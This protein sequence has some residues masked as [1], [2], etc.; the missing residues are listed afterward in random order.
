MNRLSGTL[1]AALLAAGLAVLT[2]ADAPQ[3]TAPAVSGG[4]YPQM[5][6]PQ[7][8]KVPARF[9]SYHDYTEATQLLQ[10]LA[11]AYPQYAHLQSLGKSYGGREMWV[12][13]VTDPATGAADGKPA[14]WIDGGIHANEIQASEVV[15]Y[16]AW[17][18]LESQATNSYVQRLLRERTFYL[19]PMMSPDS[20]DAHFHQP[21]DT[22]SP[23]SGQRPDDEDH[24]GLVDEDGPDDMDGDGSITQMRVAD[25]NGRWKPDPDFPQRMIHCKPDEP[26]QYTLLGEEG[27]DNDGDGLVNE[28][29]PGGYDPNRNWGW[30]WQPDYVQWGAD[31]YPFSLPEDR[32][33][34]DFIRAHPN[35]AGAQSYHNAG[36]MILHGPGMQEGNYEPEDNRLFDQ[37]G[38]KGEELLPSYKS[39]VCWR[40]LYTVYGGEFDWEYGCCGILAITNELFSNYDYFHNP[41]G[42]GAWWGGPDDA[43]KF[44]ADLLLSQGYVP[45]HPID[46][47]Q[48]GKIEVGGEKKSWGRQPPSFMLEEECHRNMAFTLYHADQLPLVS[49]QS[50][51]ARA[52]PGGLTE[53]TAAIA[54]PHMAPTRLAVD[55]AHGLSRPDRVTLSGAE[56][57]PADVLAGYWS[58]SPF[59]LHPV[60]QKTGPQT[61]ELRRVPGM[62][63]VYCRWLVR[64]GGP[65]TVSV[66]S[67]K[68]GKASADVK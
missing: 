43:R 32:L 7:H 14:M 47:P 46:H 15:L 36:A 48:Y 30:D 16:T 33:V 29:G 39:M 57:A 44:D 68:G 59:F 17:F 13:T 67:V 61:V 45:W 26:G 19:M 34:A 40:D 35:I 8:P 28:D 11:A 60:E 50:A 54:D 49:V 64:G 58:D 25:P 31:R 22:D 23:R 20:R 52:L 4:D 1:A 6:A 62:G 12:L 53:V 56:G 5:G 27:F 38:A 24:D 41:K 10:Q 37:L 2:S 21:N 66:D 18:L 63:A 3:L 55:V 9:D 65:F 42:E 51:T